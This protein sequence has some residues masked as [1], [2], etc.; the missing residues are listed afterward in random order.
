[1]NDVL[2]EMT[3]NFIEMIDA[4]L[5]EK[6]RIRKRHS[7]IWWT[8]I[9]TTTQTTVISKTGDSTDCLILR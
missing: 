2:L 8:R 6:G 9:S 3:Q 1:M 7:R 4:D 5:K